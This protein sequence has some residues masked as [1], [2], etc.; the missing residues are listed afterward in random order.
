[1]YNTTNYNVTQ[2]VTQHSQCSIVSIFQFRSQCHLHHKSYANLFVGFI[3]HQYVTKTT[4]QSGVHFKPNAL[5]H[6]AKLKKRKMVS[7]FTQLAVNT[8]EVGRTRD[9]RWKLRREA[10]WFPGYR[11]FFQPPKCLHQAMLTRKPFYISFI[12]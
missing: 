3:E 2:Y 7:V 4:F 10:E 12:K 6:D 9:K 1:M 5:A 8:R 11:V